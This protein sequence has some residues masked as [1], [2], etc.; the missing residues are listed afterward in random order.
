MLFS[1][2]EICNK[3]QIFHIFGHNHYGNQG[4]AMYIPIIEKVFI[5]QLYYAWTLVK[6]LEDWAGTTLKAAKKA[7]KN[8][9]R[10]LYLLICS[11]RPIANWKLPLGY[12]MA[13]L[14]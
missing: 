4:L 9:P 1:E 10:N 11:W 5:V 2:S 7:C 14:Q 8:D 13:K 6:C 12:K 3:P